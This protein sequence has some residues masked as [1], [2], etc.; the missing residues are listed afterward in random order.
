MSWQ[1]CLRQIDTAKALT[2]GFILLNT[3]VNNNAGD[4]DGLRRL[5]YEPGVLEAALENEKELSGVSKV[6]RHAP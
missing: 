3:R 2:T 6:E 5:F 1:I 4:D